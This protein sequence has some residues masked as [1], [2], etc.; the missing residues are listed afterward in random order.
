MTLR[1]TRANGEEIVIYHREHPTRPPLRIR[2]DTQDDERKRDPI[3]VEIS[4]NPDYIVLRSELA[5][6]D[7]FDLSYFLEK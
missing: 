2:I 7:D 5:D 3:K 6:R 4:S 1:F